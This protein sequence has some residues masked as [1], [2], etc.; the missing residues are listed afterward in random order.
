MFS[1]VPSRRTRAVPCAPPCPWCGEDGDHAVPAG[2]A[3]APSV[4]LAVGGALARVGAWLAVGDDV[5]G[6]R[7]VVA[8]DALTRGL[9][10]PT[11]V[12]LRAAHEVSGAWR[13][14]ALAGAR[15]A[16]GR[17]L[18]AALTALPA[19][20]RGERVWI[21]ELAGLVLEPGE[22]TLSLRLIAEPG[23]CLVHRVTLTVDSCARGSPLAGTYVALDGD[24]PARA[25]LVARW[26]DGALGAVREITGDPGT[27][28]LRAI[29]GG[30]RVLE[31]RVEVGRHGLRGAVWTEVLRAVAR[32]AVTEISLRHPLGDDVLGL[33]VAPGGRSQ[34]GLAELCAWVGRAA[35]GAGRE[36]ALMG[37]WE[38]VAGETTDALVQ[39]IV[40]AWDDP[41]SPRVATP[42]E[43]ARGVRDVAADREW[44]GRYVRAPGAWGWCR[45]RAAR[46]D[47]L[48]AWWPGPMDWARLYAPRG[49]GARSPAVRAFWRRTGGA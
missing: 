41:V 39:G 18:T 5:R 27:L 33:A 13:G 9:V 44:L 8:G 36:G 35:L 42:W 26:T 15:G 28:G 30:G 1:L 16:D 47:G 12:R 37:A 29:H 25:A 24:H 3:L 40:G 45:G 11:A 48:R 6:L 7:V 34:G 43:H 17:V 19:G 38:A 2:A 23:G 49:S 31:G 22:A 4:A 21:V 14:A 46:G 20:V 10:A 32:G